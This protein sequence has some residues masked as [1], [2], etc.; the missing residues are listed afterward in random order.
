MIIRVLRS[1]P[2]GSCVKLRALLNKFRL[3]AGITFLEAPVF[4]VEQRERHFLQAYS[5]D[6]VVAQMDRVSASET[7]RHPLQ[8]R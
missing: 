1:L 8:A 3:W 5:I 7:G 6:A 4:S 2:N